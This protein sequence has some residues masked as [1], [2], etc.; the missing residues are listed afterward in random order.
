MVKYIESKLFDGV[1]RKCASK[2]RVNMRDSGELGAPI[3]VSVG[4]LRKD[5]C[6]R[7][8]VGVVVE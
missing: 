4:T 1:L 5:E 3:P 8:G 6:E 2:L 7:M